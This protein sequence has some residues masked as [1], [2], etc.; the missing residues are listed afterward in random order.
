MAKRVK[1]SR[2]RVSAQSNVVI[3]TNPD[4]SR[5]FVAD[6]EAAAQ[7]VPGIEHEVMDFKS[8]A[9][10]AAI[11]EADKAVLA[12][13]ATCRVCGR[14]GGRDEKS[15]GVVILFQ[16]DDAF[17][18]IECTNKSASMRDAI[19]GPRGRR[20]KKPKTPTPAEVAEARHMRDVGAR[21]RIGG[22]SA[23]DIDR[24]I[25][26]IL[27]PLRAIKLLPG[28]N[29]Q[30]R[31]ALSDYISTVEGMIGEKSAPAPQAQAVSSKS[32]PLSFE[33]LPAKVQ[34]EIAALPKSPSVDELV[35]IK[36]ASIRRREQKEAAIVAAVQEDVVAE[37]VPLG[38]DLETWTIEQ[39][40]NAVN[41]RFRAPIGGKEV[42]Q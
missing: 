39:N 17:E 38:Y 23:E 5:E 19:G 24:D 22:K 36:P 8:A 25:D 13:C 2:K 28:I 26:T 42:S 3:T 9:I 7:L 4:G 30:T 10:E 31:V 12:A 34:R 33:M 14:P 21:V 40:L 35:A 11:A 37:G 29:M 1:R 27:G 18:C 15:A 41:R 20:F 32:D 16:R 6:P